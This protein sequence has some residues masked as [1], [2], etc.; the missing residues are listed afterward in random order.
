MH[1]R[2]TTN[3]HGENAL[4]YKLQYLEELRARCPHITPRLLIVDDGCDGKDPMGVTSGKAAE[5]LLAQRQTEQPISIETKVIY[6]QDALTAH[7]PLLPKGLHSTTQSMKG[8]AVLY[9]LAYA[10]QEWTPDTKNNHILAVSD[11]DLSIDPAHLPTFIRTI[12]E[13][14]CVVATGSRFETASVQYIEEARKGPGEL[15]AE[16]WRKLLPNLA[17]SSQDASRGF[18]AI[19]APFASSIYKNV[20][21]FSFTYQAEMLLLAAKHGPHSLL[22]VPIAYIDSSALSNFQDDALPQTYFQQ[23]QVVQD[24]ARRYNEPSPRALLDTIANAGHDPAAAEAWW[25]RVAKDKCSAEQ[26]IATQPQTEV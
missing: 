19:A 7:S 15:Y 10:T 6:L 13:Q 2:S 8:G 11:A 14:N 9:A 5:Q 20:Q 16:V 21:V 17:S 12:L 3:P 26:L 1:A 18:L 25:L 4:L 22:P 23:A 24:I